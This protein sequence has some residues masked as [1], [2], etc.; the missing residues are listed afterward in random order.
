VTQPEFQQY[1]G[2]SPEKDGFNI[3]YKRVIYRCVRY[4]Y[5]LL[6]V[7]AV[8][9]ILA[10]VQNRYASKVYPVSASIIIKEAKQASGAEL[11][12]TN[13]IIDPYR[14]YYNEIYIIRSYPL[15][16]SVL[17]DLNFST[18]F[19]R[20]GNILTSE[21]YDYPIKAYVLNQDEIKA[22]SLSF[23]ILDGK[24]FELSPLDDNKI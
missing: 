17:E 5:V 24:Q 13:D 20:E 3:D 19:Y 23:K 4:W 14:N 16:Q 21:L 10:F 6:L 7:L 9:L 12:Y 8:C 22:S 18:A 11:L 1:Y 15:I 2:E